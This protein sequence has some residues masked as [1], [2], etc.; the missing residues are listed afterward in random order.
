MEY[1]KGKILIVDDEILI[2]KLLRQKLTKEGYDCDEA[3]GVSSALKK[4]E[5]GLIDLVITDIRMPER[6]GIELLSIVKENFPNT[7]VIMATGV[8][9]MGI[10]IECMKHGADDYISKPFDPELVK[11]SVQKSLEKRKVELEIRGYQI[12]LEHEIERQTDE[13]RKLSLGA[14][15]ALVIALEAKDKYTAGHSRR[16]SEIALAIAKEIGLPSKDRENLRWGSLL[17]DVGKIAVDQMI[18]NKPGRL[19]T[20][21]HEHIMIHSQVG[22]G[23]IKPVV[24]PMVVEIVEHHHDRYDGKGSHQLLSGKDI[25][26]GALILAVAD[27]FDAMTSDRPYRRAL[28]IATSLAEIQRCSG[29]QFDPE[30]V[31]VFVKLY[32]P[33]SLFAKSVVLSK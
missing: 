1:L 31:K 14:I 2:R 26:F 3:D 6:S 33:E 23:I 5:T 30:V 13:I 7:S 20:A 24:N 22:A 17:H 29:S 18:Q 32:A 28:P 15:E 27:T 4:I 10:A 21:E 8:P 9:E 11:E 16:V 19:T 12:D 25:P